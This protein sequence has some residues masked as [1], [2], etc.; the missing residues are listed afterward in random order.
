MDQWWKPS[1]HIPPGECLADGSCATC[2]ST[3]AY[4][5]DKKGFFCFG[6]WY[7]PRG[8]RQFIGIHGEED[9]ISST[10]ADR[11]AVFGSLIEGVMPRVVQKQPGSA[12]KKKLSNTMVA[13]ARYARYL[14][15]RKTEE[16]ETALKS[17]EE[18]VCLMQQQMQSLR[19]EKE[20]AEKK[21]QEMHLSVG[22]AP[23]G[24]NEYHQV[25]VSA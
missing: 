9:Y 18:V 19:E 3:K 4:R 5:V 14:G 10:T 21:A 25:V 8:L 22:R 23:T 11:S 13:E 7:R 24:W 15:E 2:Q 17:A 1:L 20:N 16:T 12:T 6:A